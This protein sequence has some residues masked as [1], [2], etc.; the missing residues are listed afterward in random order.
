MPDAPPLVLAGWR[1]WLFDKTAAVMKELGLEAQVRLLENLPP[2]DLPAL[3]NGA[4]V[5]VL[6]SHY[7]GFGFPVLEAM[8]CQVPCVIS[9]RASLPELG[10]EAALQVDPDDPDA[11][12]EALRRALTDSDLRAGMRRKGLEQVQKFRWENAARETV[13]LYRRVLAG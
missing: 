9:N 3:Y 10:G 12:A 2:A 8:G 5:F 11:L 6:P 13:A 4:S 1:G 7:E